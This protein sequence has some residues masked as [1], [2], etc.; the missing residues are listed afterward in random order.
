MDI[1]FDV[2]Y[3]HN[4][5]DGWASAAILG[6]PFNLGVGYKTAINNSSILNN[7]QGKTCGIVDFSFPID[8]MKFFQKICKELV[9]IDHHKDSEPVK[10]LNIKGIHDISKAGCALTWDYFK[11][12]IPYPDVVKYAADRDIWTFAY[13]E[14]E[15]YCHGISLLDTI[16]DPSSELWK[17]LLNSNELTDKII[18]TGNIIIKK[19]NN[20]ILWHNRLRVHIVKQGEDEFLL[21]NCTNAISETAQGMMDCFGVEKILLWDVAKGVISLHGRGKGVRTFFGGLLKGHE[22]AC[23]GSI[24]L[25]DGMKFI[26]SLYKMSRRIGP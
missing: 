20:D 9:W 22:D 5:L 7:C 1:K 19:L 16:G 17:I 23:G 21:A 14:T 26:Q 10:E 4:D 15:A 13:E 8:T 3:H 2:V 6:A 24:E 25:E 18:E 12:D 11:G